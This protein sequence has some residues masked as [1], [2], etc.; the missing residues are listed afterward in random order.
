MNQSSNREALQKGL[1]GKLPSGADLPAHVVSSKMDI[2]GVLISD[3]RITLAGTLDGLIAV[4]MLVAGEPV[5][6][7]CR[8]YATISGTL[9]SDE[10][11]ISG[12]GRFRAKFSCTSIHLNDKA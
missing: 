10:M 6:N 9:E 1:D 7:N 8:F 5:M 4:T 3:G 12:S 2:E 11:T